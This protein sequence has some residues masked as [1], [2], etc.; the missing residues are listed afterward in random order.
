MERFFNPKLVSMLELSERAPGVLAC[1]NPMARIDR[2]VVAALK[3]Y[4]VSTPKGRARILFHENDASALHE[5]LIAA[6]RM[7]IW[8]P[9]LNE[10]PPQSW[11]VLEGEIAFI[12]YAPP[13]EIVDAVRLAANDESSPSFLRFA[14][15]EWYTMVPL[16]QMVVYLE[17]KRGPH[18]ETRFADWGPQS[19]EDPKSEVL[20]DA[21][22]EL[23]AD[24][25]GFEQ[26][27]N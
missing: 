16:S 11:S 3:R 18:V 9:M 14:A 19:S 23:A 26:D 17:T 1:N 24:P 5:M 6:P 2:D 13:G 27:L 21:L 10:R 15:E 22:R 7:T 8:P 25:S 12:R 4:A 20:F